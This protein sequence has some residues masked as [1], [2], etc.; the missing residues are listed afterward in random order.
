[1]ELEEKCLENQVFNHIKNL[2]PRIITLNDDLA[3]HP[4][5][6]G[7]EYESA[8]KIVKVLR[9]SSIEVE[10]PFAGLPT[11]FKACIN[12]TSKPRAKI[13][14][15]AEYDALPG[16]GHACG[17]CVSACI[18][19]LA[20]I[21]LSLTRENFDGQIDIIGTPD[22]ELNGGKIIMAEQGVFDDYDMAIMIHL[23]NKNRI[24]TKLLALDSLKFIFKGKAS[25]A[26]ASPWDGKN[27]LNG[28]QLMF[29]AIDMLRQHVMPDVRIHGIITNGGQA[30]NIVPEEAAAE[31]LIRAS[32][33]EYLNEVTEMVRNCARGAAIS[34][35]TE[36]SISNISS[37]YDDLT[38]N[39]AGYNIIKQVY[40]ELGLEISQDDGFFGSSDIGNVSKK[41]PAF[42]PTLA[43]TDKNIALHTREFA[44]LV[45]GEG[46]YKAIQD[47]AKILAAVV[48]RV[49]NNEKILMQ[50]RDC[51]NESRK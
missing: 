40:N 25:H 24:E 31:F 47:G 43:L 21:A 2:L 22:E 4:E 16:L 34:T 6:S 27:A 1:M 23:D 7:Y 38:S 18:S 49:L 13:A 17:H 41:C 5:E 42:H 12:K 51:H 9:D 48:L 14:L 11:A 46:A 15:L 10:F 35:G 29:H 33:R 36:V 32:K 19:L 44:S 8:K 20:G 50:I 45:K 39:V 37:S 3:D 28:V 26:S 30:S